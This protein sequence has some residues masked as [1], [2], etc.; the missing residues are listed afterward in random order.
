MFV[1]FIQKGRYYMGLGGGDFF[2]FLLQRGVGLDPCRV[3]GSEKSSV[4]LAT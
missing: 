4:S 3:K 2:H 1:H